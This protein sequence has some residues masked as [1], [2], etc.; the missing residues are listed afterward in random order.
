MRKKITAL[1]LCIGIFLTGCTSVGD[2]TS[3]SS[4][5]GLS[6]ASSQGASTPTSTPKPAP[7]ST[8]VDGKT[9]YEQLF[10]TGPILARNTD[11]LWGYID[12]AGNY[13]VEPRFTDA[14]AFQ[15]NGLA[16][17]QDSE[18]GLWGYINTSGEYAI[19]AK[20]SQVSFNGFRN[21]GLAAVYEAGTNLSGYIDESGEYAFPPLS[22]STVS[23]FINGLAIV[24]PPGAVYY[25]DETGEQ[26]YPE[27]FNE[28]YHFSE[29]WAPVMYWGDYG[30]LDRS[31]EFY[32]FPDAQD[33]SR[34]QNGRA[35]VKLANGKWRMIDETLQFVSDA[36]FD[37]IWSGTTSG[38]PFYRGKDTFAGEW[39]PNGSARCIVC[40]ETIHE[41][42]S[43]YSYTAYNYYVIDTDGN[44]V[45]PTD[46]KNYESATWSGESQIVVREAETH[47][48]GVIDAEGNWVIPLVDRNI[49]SIAVDGIRLSEAGPEQN[50]KFIDQEG[51]TVWEPA[52]PGIS[53]VGRYRDILTV[54]ITDEESPNL[55]MYSYVDHDGNPITDLTF[56]MARDFSKDSSYARAAVDGLWGI[57]DGEGNWL[58]E[59]KF[60]SFADTWVVD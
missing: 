23:D 54:Y 21:N 5:A 3:T 32:A 6:S 35:F 2:T 37:S 1:T 59:P 57:I 50:N 47:D 7:A 36:E 34:F 28:A 20:Y 22:D 53:V 49:S 19:E 55:G 56:T 11:G 12:S 40:I 31:G 42:N 48:M 38:G 13:V 4:G 30:Y 14:Y 24:G 15:E 25:I 33:V 26:V 51:N 17:V 44:I 27:T 52:N 43:S 9:A 16:A 46:G 39:D 60:Q 45:F 58:I 41:A 29:D 10:T 8:P 18:T